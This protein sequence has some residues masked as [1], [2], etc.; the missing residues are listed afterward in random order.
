MEWFRLVLVL[1]FCKKNVCYNCH[2]I[3]GLCNGDWLHVIVGC[4]VMDWQLLSMCENL[5]PRYLLKWFYILFN[6]EGSGVLKITLH[7]E[8]NLPKYAANLV[9][10]VVFYFHFQKAKN[11]VFIVTKW[12]L[13]NTLNYPFIALKCHHILA[14]IL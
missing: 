5:V 12:K 4:F 8:P 2:E 3:R 13:S 9:F 7:T 11:V 10:C 1:K 6:L 14:K